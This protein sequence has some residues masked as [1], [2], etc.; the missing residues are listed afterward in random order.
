MNIKLSEAL[1]EGIASDGEPKTEP[2]KVV[3]LFCGAGGLD[4]GFQK[5]GFKVEFAADYNEAAVKTYNYNH[6]K[7]K[8]HTLDLLET[9]AENVHLIATKNLKLGSTID[10]II[11]GPPCQGFSRANANRCHTDPR[12]QLALKYAEIVNKFYTKSNLK[13]FLFE[14][15]P[16]IKAKKNAEFLKLLRDSLSINFNIYEKE[17]NAW[18][19]GV[20]QIRKRYFI[21]GICKK[22]DLTH[23]EFPQP[24]KNKLKTVG[25]VLKD[26][27]NPVYYSRELDQSEIS[28][29]PNHWT[30]RP[31][32]KKFDSGEMP[33][34]GRSFIKLDWDKPSRTVAY[35][36][37]EIHIHPDGKRRLSI[38]EAMRLQGFP[39][40]YVLQGNLSEQVKQISNAVPP[41]VA[42]AL[43]K[44]LKEQI[45]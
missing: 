40:K 44:S 25:S 41:P 37:R 17:I 27:P 10:G 30:M 21:V 45:Q 34:G 33:N 24:I 14:N 31:K 11:G 3:S 28:F 9:S 22:N 13:F 42:M 39:K 4:I 6:K 38:Y 5:Q 8:A 2:M 7:K 29:H 15:V 26:L 19:F 32:S 20:P 23:F 1:L 16:E 18:D 36:N 35:G 12:N 43:A